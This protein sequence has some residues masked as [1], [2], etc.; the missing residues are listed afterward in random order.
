MERVIEGTKNTSSRG[1]LFGHILLYGKP[2]TGKTLFA[3]K[4]AQVSHMDF[5]VMSGPAFDQFKPHEAIAEIKNLFTWANRTNNGL[6]LFID[7]CDSFLEDRATLSPERVRVLNE[8]I[9]QTGTESRKVSLSLSLTATQLILLLMYSLTHS[10]THSLT[11]SLSLPRC[12]HSSCWSLRPIDLTFLILQ[13][14]VV[15]R[16]R[17][18][19]F[20]LRVTRCERC[21]IR[22][23]TSTFVRSTNIADRC[24]SS[25]VVTAVSTVML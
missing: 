11:L 9:N 19:S 13:C 2:G 3:E 18:N 16:N 22:M 4:L 25:G 21:S 7:E 12:N 15:A 10:L 24:S 14:K 8:F 17:S 6:L 5:A 23:S 20:H 1:G